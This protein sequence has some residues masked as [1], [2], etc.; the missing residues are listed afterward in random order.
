M[1]AASLGMGRM[2]LFNH[3]IEYATRDCDNSPKAINHNETVVTLSY[4]NGF[5]ERITTEIVFR[6]DVKYVKI[7]GTASTNIEVLTGVVLD[8]KTNLKSEHVVLANGQSYTCRS[9]RD[10]V[11]PIGE[12]VTI[13]EH[14]DA[15]SNTF[16][17]VVTKKTLVNP[18]WCGINIMAYNEN[19]EQLE[20]LTLD[21]YFGH[22][23]TL[24][25]RD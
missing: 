25:R 16:G 12:V 20:T 4:D 2:T 3:S 22:E 8:P 10:D 6:I 18:D 19:D 15:H 24:G 14:W 9:D 7:G 11:Y 23:G 17:W 5:G 1:V 21:P 13:F